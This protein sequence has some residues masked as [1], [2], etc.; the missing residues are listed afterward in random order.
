MIL[1]R[2]FE[3][4]MQYTAILAN[5]GL[6]L[7]IFKAKKMAGFSFTEYLVLVLDFRYSPIFDIQNQ[8]KKASR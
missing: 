6:K 5:F 4:L 8:L 3:L 2:I 1:N 7:A